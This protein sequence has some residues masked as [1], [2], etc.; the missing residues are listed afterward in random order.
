MD[1]GRF[2]IVTAYDSH[3]YHTGLCQCLGHFWPLLVHSKTGLKLTRGVTDGLLI[4]TFTSYT[5]PLKQLL[6]AHKLG[7]KNIK[8]LHLVHF[9][10]ER[11][12]RD[13]VEGFWDL[14]DPHEI[15]LLQCDAALHSKHLLLTREIMNAAKQAFK[16]NVNAQS[17]KEHAIILHHSTASIN[18][19]K[20]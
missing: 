10:S 13:E 15:L 9:T 2:Q 18:D 11:R 14:K 7:M 12:L 16:S 19:K 3:S 17:H 6:K 1:C 20:M 8:F 4:L 5:C